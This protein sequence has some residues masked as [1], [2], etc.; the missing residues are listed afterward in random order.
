MT[1]NTCRR[2]KGTGNLEVFEHHAGGV[3]KRCFGTGIDPGKTI[4]KTFGGIRLTGNN[5]RQ[6]VEIDGEVTYFTSMDEARRF[7]NEAY[8]ARKEA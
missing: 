8:K 7:A 2:C 5:A 6:M 1:T 3:C 4:D